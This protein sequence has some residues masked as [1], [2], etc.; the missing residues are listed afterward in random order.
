MKLHGVLRFLT[1]LVVLQAVLGCG[2]NDDLPA[3]SLNGVWHL[4]GNRG[5]EQYPL[6]SL[7][8]IVNG[9]QISGRGEMMVSCDN[10]SLGF[11][12]SLYLSGQIAS[13]GTFQL[14][15]PAS[16]A[17]SNDTEIVI[18]G[19]V[20]KRGQSTWNGTYSFKSTTQNT[21]CIINQSS[22]FTATAAGP[23]NGGYAGTLNRSGSP[24]DKIS[25]SAKLLQGAPA[26]ITRPVVTTVYYL[27]ITGTL[28]VSGSPCFA[29]GSIS[30]RTISEIAGD[31]LSLDFL[32]EDGSQVHLAGFFDSSAESSFW[33]LASVHGGQCDGQFLSGSL[34]RE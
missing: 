6:L 17:F 26:S 5:L 20:P 25:V 11:G 32:M 21:G 23:V 33:A 27:P 7:S 12:G 13:D 2:S 31:Y 30:E 24:S 9:N 16:S 4:A 28:S 8:L 34:S 1:A 29:R 10:R 14:G 3:A 22:A 15:V 19:T 18:K